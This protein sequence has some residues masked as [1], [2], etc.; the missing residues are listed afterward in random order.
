[1]RSEIVPAGREFGDRHFPALWTEAV[2]TAVP[3]GFLRKYM[4]AY[5]LEIAYTPTIY[6]KGKTYAYGAF[7]PYP[8]PFAQGLYTSYLS[9]LG[10]GFPHLPSDPRYHAIL[11]AVTKYAALTKATVAKVIGRCR[12]A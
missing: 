3:D 8:I 9:L 12:E 5:G 1:V 4:C 2:Q 7:I 11:S 10:E 6:T